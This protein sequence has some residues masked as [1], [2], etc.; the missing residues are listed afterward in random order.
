MTF[1]CKQ[2]DRYFKWKVGL[3]RHQENRKTPCRKALYSCSDCNKVFV[4][5][6][7]LSKHRK[8]YCKSKPILSRDEVNNDD[9]TSS[10]TLSNLLD[11]L[12]NRDHQQIPAT[13]PI[14][15][16]ITFSD[17]ISTLNLSSPRSTPPS[18][19]TSTAITKREMVD[20]NPFDADFAEAIEQPLEIP[21]TQA[22]QNV[23]YCFDDMLIQ[24]MSEVARMEGSFRNNATVKGE[25][26]RVLGGMLKDGLMSSHEHDQMIHA[27]RLFVRL[28]DLI[29]MNM[30]SFNRR[31]MIEI[32]VD[33][34]EM[35]KIT[36][37]VLIEMCM[38]IS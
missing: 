10:V 21:P 20:D 29:H 26:E 5:T 27:N 11:A 15:P 14:D 2:C 23:L 16:S 1:Y 33:L 19:P 30:H 34:F 24:W 25:V 6:Q 32:L 22:E 9:N 3:K 37:V 12:Y 13:T 38:N 17:L 36:K 28:H 8:L 35:G 4:S 31:E 18:Q 7:S